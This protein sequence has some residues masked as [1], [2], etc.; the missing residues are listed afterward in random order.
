LKRVAVVGATGFVGEQLLPILSKKHLVRAI[1]RRSPAST[2]PIE[3][4]QCDL[5][6]LKQLEEALKD[7]DTAIYLVHSMQPKKGLMQGSFDNIDLFLADNFSRAVRKCGVKKVIY[8]GGIIPK[9][10]LSKHLLS[11]YEVE[12]TLHASGAQFFGLRAG[13]IVGAGGSSFEMMAKIVKRLPIMICPRWTQNKSTP[14]SIDDVVNVIDKLVDSTNSEPGTYDIGGLST[15]S[16]VDLMKTT[17]TCLKL[18]RYF[19][20]T[21]YLTLSLSKLWVKVFGSA[22]Y[23]LVSPLVDSLKHSLEIPDL[24]LQRS[25]NLIPRDIAG[26]INSAL[27]NQ[28][29]NTKTKSGY[30]Q[31]EKLVTS[32]QRIPLPSDFSAMELS[33]LYAKWLK[34]FF[35][36]LI[37]IV[38][39]DGQLR[40][41]FGFLEFIKKNPSLLVLEFSEARSSDDRVLFYIGGGLLDGGSAK[42]NGRLE[43]REVLNRSSALAAV[44]QFKPRLPWRFYLVTQALI[45]LYVMSS[46]RRYLKNPKFNSHNASSRFHNFND[47]RK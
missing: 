12:Q 25:L 33:F 37:N 28:P 10:A 21:Q 38:S 17:A 14:I 34:K 20:M 22:P 44:L 4:Q 29:L 16:Y 43:F 5:F 47:D 13:L 8:L 40:F 26:A 7:V 15:L 2:G 42:F 41:N 23:S 3:Y 31:S 27:S 6:S 30:P 39:K 11:R 46:F 24:K 32:I 1:A 35:W 18:K 36:P 45:H 19:F 9:G